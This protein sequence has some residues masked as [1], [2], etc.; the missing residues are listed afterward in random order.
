VAM[1]KPVRAKA[2]LRWP[3]TGVYLCDNCHTRWAG[4]AGTIA[5]RCTVLRGKL[6]QPCN[7][8]YYVL[9][10]PRAPS[11]GTVSAM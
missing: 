3:V 10:E 4:Q 11:D 1:S 8:A 5:T 2:G 9:I 6:Q 7:C